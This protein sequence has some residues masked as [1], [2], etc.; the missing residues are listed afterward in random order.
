MRRVTRPIEC[1]IPFPTRERTTYS[2]PNPIA[3][4]AD[5]RPGPA[6]ISIHRYPVSAAPG[7][8]KKLVSGNRG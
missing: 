3:H 1:V 4:T 2:E 7:F 6:V 8:Q 5:P